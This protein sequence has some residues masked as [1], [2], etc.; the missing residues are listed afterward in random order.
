MTDDSDHAVCG[1]SL[2]LFDAAIMGSNPAQVM[3]G[4]LFSTIHRPHSLVTLHRR[5]IV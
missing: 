4:W 2:D 1:V 3:D 5:Y